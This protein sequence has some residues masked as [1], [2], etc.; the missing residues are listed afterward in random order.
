MSYASKGPKMCPHAQHST[1]PQRLAWN[2][3]GTYL[4]SPDA[5][6]SRPLTCEPDGEFFLNKTPSSPVQQ[7]IYWDPY[8]SEVEAQGTLAGP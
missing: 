2:Y 3:C 1:A 6:L 8:D 7:R 5:R 4:G